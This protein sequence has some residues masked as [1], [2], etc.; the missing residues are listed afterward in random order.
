[1]A[2]YS[3]LVT[4]QLIDTIDSYSGFDWYIGGQHQKNT[5]TF[6]QVKSQIKTL[7]YLGGAGSVLI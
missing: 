3:V 7:P 6:Y 4:G 1:M 2:T 5:W